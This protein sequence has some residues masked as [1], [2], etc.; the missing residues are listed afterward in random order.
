MMKAILL[1][2]A[3]LVAA[4]VLAQVNANTGA[5]AKPGTAADKVKGRA[6]QTITTGE[7]GKMKRNTGATD[8]MG[9]SEGTTHSHSISTSTDGIA[10]TRSPTVDPPEGTASGTVAATGTTAAS[11]TEDIGAGAA[12]STTA[13]S[14]GLA[15]GTSTGLGTGTS[16]GLSTGTSTGLNTGFTGVGGPNGNLMDVAG[17]ML[18]DSARVEQVMRGRD[19]SMKASDLLNQAMLTLMQGGANA[20][21]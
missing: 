4:P 5:S 6:N 7:Q 15:T 3:M 13:P 1:A 14:A 21:R 9:G 8:S 11:N 16:T 19:T 18:G 12:A 10:D 17:E 20:P 2:G